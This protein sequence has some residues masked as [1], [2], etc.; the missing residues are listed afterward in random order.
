M[1]ARRSV[2]ALAAVGV[3]VAACGALQGLDKFEKCNNDEECLLIGGGTTD[4]PFT[5][6]GPSS[7]DA[8]Q[9]TKV[10]EAC[11]DIASD[12]DNCGR[13][14]NVC[15]TGYSCS[16]GM[17]TCALSTC[18][19]S[20]GGA[21][22]G[23]GGG[24]LACVDLT[25]DPK[26]CGGCGTTCAFPNAVAKCAGSVCGI[27]SCAPGFVDCDKT[28][29]NG[30]ECAADSCLTG[31]LCAKRVF[32][33]SLEYD[34]NLGGLAGADAKCQAR[35][36]AAALPGT[37]KA[38]LSDAAATPDTR[39]AKA[40]IPYRLVDG[41]LVANNY[42]DLTDGTLAAPINKTEAGLAP[43]T[44]DFCGPAKV[45]VWTS[46]SVAGLLL[47]PNGTCTNWTSTATG[48][49]Q[50]GDASMTTGGWTNQCGGGACGGA[51]VAPL[52]CFQQ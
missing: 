10:V 15:A 33:T 45:M 41:T 39:F 49:A 43:P 50:W 19:G 48:G 30:C 46:T 38:W 28:L 32:T 17:C 37:Y 31:N 22:D 42:A 25:S 1:A 7:G 8:T 40:T 6:D 20:D 26:N 24:A 13:C 2:L 14:G 52:Y 5:S 35:A 9:D 11:G 12:R 36:V 18:G 29:A 3:C 47:A 34:G 27:Q 4:G 44:S 21:S 16:G 23:G 51:F